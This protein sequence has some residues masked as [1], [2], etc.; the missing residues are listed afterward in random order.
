MNSYFKN[1]D[2]DRFRHAAE[3]QSERPGERSDG[4]CVALWDT[5]PRLRDRT[6]PYPKDEQA[7]CHRYIDAFESVFLDGVPHPQNVYW[8]WDYC[9]S[10]EVNKES[11]ILALLL[12][13]EMCEDATQRKRA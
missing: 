10:V 4:A 3:L 11:R 6:E 9:W 5:F 13:A 12:C 8:F 1:L 2:P 7:E